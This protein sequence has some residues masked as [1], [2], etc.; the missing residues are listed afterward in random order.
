M[1]ICLFFL[2]VSPAIIN[3]HPS[4][5]IVAQNDTA[6][7]S[8]DASGGELTYQWQRNGMNIEPRTGKFDG[9]NNHTLTVIDVQ[10]EDTGLY[11]CIV[12]NGAGDSSTSDEAILRISKSNLRQ[13]L[14]LDISISIMY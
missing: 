9:I 1:I 12:F 11:K 8:V 5:Q 2:T 14:Y 10:E 6:E 13:L 3:T 7:F 4:D